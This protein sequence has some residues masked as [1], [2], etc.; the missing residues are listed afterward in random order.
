MKELIQTEK[1][2]VYDLEHIVKGYLKEFARAGKKIPADLRGKKNIIFGNIE[3]IYEFHKNDFLLELESCQD[4]PSLVGATFIMKSNEFEMYAA[5]C[6]NKPSSEA[7]RLDYINLPFF[8]VRFLFS[9]MQTKS[10]FLVFT[11]ISLFGFLYS[12]K[13]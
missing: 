13:H 4:Q 6:K 2:Y 9:E 12:V 11:S 8:K 5:Y 10:N 1:D 3:Q 7:L